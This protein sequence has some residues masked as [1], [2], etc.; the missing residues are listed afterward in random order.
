MSNQFYNT[1]SSSLHYKHHTL[2][3]CIKPFTYQD[4]KTFSLKCVPL[5]LLLLSIG[6][7]EQSPPSHSYNALASLG[8]FLR[9]L[10]HAFC[11]RFTHDCSKGGDVRVT[12]Y[13]HNEH[14]G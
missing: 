8:L 1:G 12:V 7:N 4:P 13:W 2:F 3:A 5:A 14:E 11:R 6:E 10:H 9:R